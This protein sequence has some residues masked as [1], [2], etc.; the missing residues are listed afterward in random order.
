MDSVS[1][2]LKDGASGEVGISSKVTKTPRVGWC[3]S[4]F[5]F[6]LSENGSEQMSTCAC[7]PSA[8]AHSLPWQ[9]LGLFPFSSPQRPHCPLLWSSLFLLSEPFQITLAQPVL[10][11]SC[12]SLI[13]PEGWMHNPSVHQRAGAFWEDGLSARHPSPLNLPSKALHASRGQ[14]C[15]CPSIHTHGSELPMMSVL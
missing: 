3:L 5:L 11:P 15:G 10:T 12:L 7:S 9:S 4:V 13:G 2:G 14:G 6:A 8:P 1:P